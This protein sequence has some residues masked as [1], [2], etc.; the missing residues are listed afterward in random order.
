MIEQEVRYLEA[1]FGNTFDKLK[2]S[3]VLDM[4]SKVGNRCFMKAK[5]QGKA[6]EQKRILKIID[7]Y[8]HDDETKYVLN[9]LKAKIKGEKWDLME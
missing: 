7:E 3:K 8:K 4:I 2:I 1:Y 5:E 6:A 9:K